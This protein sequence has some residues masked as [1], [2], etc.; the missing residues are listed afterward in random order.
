M[1]IISRNRFM[2]TMSEKKPTFAIQ[3]AKIDSAYIEGRPRLIFDGEDIVSLKRYPYVG[4]YIPK[5]NDRVQIIGGVIQ[6][7]IV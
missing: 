5:A 3:Y 7:N 4:S 1:P 6:G 2:K